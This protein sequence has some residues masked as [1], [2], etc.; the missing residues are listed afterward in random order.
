M[1]NEQYFNEYNN[2]TYTG[3]GGIITDIKMHVAGKV[4]DALTKSRMPNIK[5]LEIGAA[6]G[7]LARAIGGDN[8]IL[9][10]ISFH[11][12]NIAGN[13]LPRTLGDATT[14]PFANNSMDRV[15]A[16][17]THEHLD[18]KGI[19]DSLAEAYRVLK[20]GGQLF[21]CPANLH[22]KK[23][24]ADVTHQTK[25]P[26]EWWRQQLV[27]SGF[28]IDNRLSV[29]LCR[30]LGKVQPFGIIPFPVFRQ[31]FFVATKWYE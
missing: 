28:I 9:Y 7:H 11:A 25:Q 8:Y 6:M 4:I 30:Q 3:Y 17:D 31:S 29:E 26:P 16:I 15:I 18:E 20:P 19:S 2:R 24:H 10:D 14:L 12:L 5:T 13:K 1:Y 21:L 23:I 27:D 22:E